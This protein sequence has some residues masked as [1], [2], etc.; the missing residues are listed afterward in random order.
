MPFSV[1]IASSNRGKIR[2]FSEL[3]LGSELEPIAPQDLGM[4]LEVEEDG[5]SYLENALAKGHAYAIAA[6]MAALAD[7]SGIEVDALGG[8]PGIYSAR[9]GGAGLS[10]EER[11]SLLLEQLQPADDSRRSARYRCSLVLVW[12]NGDTCRAEGTCEGLIAQA[13]RGSNGFGYDPVF[14]LPEFGKTM[15]ELSR[16]EK[17]RASHRGRA[18]RSLLAQISD[19]GGLRE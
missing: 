13:P 16:D 3:L 9:F 5:S 14:F 6:D 19:I 1:V 11:T 7:D 12:P 2:E 8:A 4:E 17:N 18:V 15:A 10:D